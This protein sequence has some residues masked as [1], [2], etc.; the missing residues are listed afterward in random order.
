MKKYA[1]TPTI[2]QMEA[3][4]CGAASLSMI[5]AYFG[6]HVS[7]EQMRIETG[8]SRDGCNAGN[9]MRAA[10]KFGL[11]CHGYRKEPEAL[12]KITPPCIIHWNFNHFVV[13]EG[14]KGNKPVI[15][16]PAIG[17]R[18]LTMQEL[19][20]CFTGIVL[21]FALTPDFKKEKKKSNI[22]DL[23]LSRLSGQ[24]EPVIQTLFV[25]FLLIFP[26]LALPMLSQVMMDN[27]L[28]SGN[29]SWFWQLIIAMS[30]IIIIKACLTLYRENV[31]LKL[32]KK[33]SLFSSRNFLFSL[34]RLPINFFDQR[35]SGDIAARIT[36]NN[37]INDF[38]IGDLAEMII[39]VV[40]LI[41]Y[42]IVLILYSP[43]LTVIAVTSLILNILILKITSN[44]LSE[45]MI[46]LQQDSGKLYGAVCAGLEIT[47]TIKAS[48]S[49]SNFIERILG[50]NAKTV[51]L[52][53]KLSR[54]QQIA[55]AISSALKIAADTAILL[56]GGYQVIKGSMTIGQ[57]VAF[58]TM[59]GYFS[60]PVQKMV[61]VVQNFQKTKANIERVEDI[62]NYPIDEKFSGK[63]N[64]EKI[65]SKLNGS[66]ELRNISFGYSSLKPPIVENF[67]CK[68]GCG[69]SVAFI[70][71]SGCGKSTVSKIVS[72]LYSPW[73]GELF[74]DG[75][76]AK[77]IPNEIM[78]ASVSTVSQN[79][80]LFSGTIRD[81]L[82]MWNKN[83]SEEDMI[84]AAK[85]ACIHDV[86]TQKPGAYDYHLSEGASNLSGGQ[87][88]RLEIARALVTNP[89]VLIMD[90]ATSALDPIVEKQIIDNIKRRGCTCI[91]IAHRLSAI[92]DCDQ[93]I[94]M[95]HGKIVQKGTH[96]ELIN[97]EGLYKDFINNN[98]GEKVHNG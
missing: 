26:G 85:D 47:S 60:E 84:S 3:T 13:F 69:S 37:D 9:I 53:Q 43:V 2:F 45:L 52:E 82:T 29:I 42:L 77:D 68:V 22:K 16:D 38:L 10:Q 17:R 31:L 46:K 62:E 76:P 86:I 41:L 28:I 81:N 80:T 12:K 92:R 34:F 19:D 67:S 40:V 11:E 63:N 71:A 4:E 74:F 21:T 75:I 49:E 88:Q 14:F 23:I 89:T 91:I 8:V 95:S 32:Q 20:D 97:S 6:K 44:K 98:E 72:G 66:V 64:K 25:G 87:R 15:N 18:V 93:I 27:V 78:N 39:D 1:K 5:L 59:F 54:L 56:V 83:V 73:N 70:G 24:Y 90:E 61:S 57:I 50:Y 51:S 48:G 94:A 79:I 58:T 35:D 65:S 30:V 96:S 55:N 33:M 36:G 7:L